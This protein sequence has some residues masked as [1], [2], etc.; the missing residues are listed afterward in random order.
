MDILNLD[1]EIWG[2]LVSWPTGDEVAVMAPSLQD[3]R[4]LDMTEAGNF[5]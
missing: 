3:Y 5:A 1:S 4:D 2:T